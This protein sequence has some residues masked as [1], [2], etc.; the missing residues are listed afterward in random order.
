MKK[1]YSIILILATAFAIHAEAAITPTDTQMWWGYF[2]ES[3]VEYLS[4]ASSLG[5]SSACTL[6][7]AIYIP[8]NDEFVGGSTIKAVRFWLG[9]DVASI[10]SDLK[11][12]ISNRQPSD[13]SGS[14]YVQTVPRS[15][16]TEGLNEVELT[17][18]FVVNNQGVYVGLTFSIGERAY[19]LKSS[20][21]DIYNAFFLRVNNK[22]WDNYGD[23]YGKLAF[24]VL[25]DGGDYPI[26]NALVDN[27]G[28]YVVKQGN[29][30][31]IPV[32]I[33]NKGKNAISSVSYTI[34]TDGGNTT[35][36]STLSVGNLAFNATY[37]ANIP[38]QSDE[39]ARKAVKTLTITKVNGV[40]N[41]SAAKVGSGS[42]ITV[43]ERPHVV[44]AVEEFTGTWCG[45]CPYGMVALAKAHEIYGNGV[46][47]IA[48]HNG[49]V[50]EC[51][52]YYP[53]TRDVH[54]FP[55]AKMNRCTD[56]YPRS[57]RLEIEIED[58]LDRTVQGS[59][60]LTANW[61]STEKNM[62]QFDTKTKFV[63]D[64]NNGQYGI[65]FVLLED[66]LKGTGYEWEQS[67][68]LSGVSGSSEMSFWYS[69]G[70]RVAGIEYN[71]VPVEAW[72]I[73]DGVDGSVNSVI[74]SGKYQEYTFKGDISSN[75]LI[76]DRG[77]LKAVALLIDRESGTI[78]NAAQAEIKDASAG[79]SDP[80]STPQRVVARY[81]IDGIQIQ[82]PRKGLNIIKLSDGRKIKVIE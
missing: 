32:V 20:G 47:L 77:K 9:E 33:T 50:M 52:G 71:H 82:T 75:K 15:A 29:S 11:V 68:Y 67:N 31:K 43:I 38:F 10:N 22:R 24:Q 51:S 76:Q 1:I 53:V 37:T 55:S 56:F 7:A 8:A 66:G 6:D 54:S 78:V 3:E 74:Q 17:S 39:Q 44:P 70:S 62:V 49:D 19:P 73:L 79:I 40:S 41:T 36:E 12:W 58:M 72:N 16:L 80:T 59:I 48:A 4:Y 63:Y 81:T 13:I 30:V 27:F 25:I 34:S 26:N 14:D 65:A 46:V 5:Y 61:T 69:A 60:E 18:P 23:D 45:Y 35:P 64:D 57:D 2:S 42:L 21:S 28:Q